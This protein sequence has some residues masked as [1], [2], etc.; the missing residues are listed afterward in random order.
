MCSKSHLGVPLDTLFA[1]YPNSTNMQRARL[2]LRDMMEDKFN[3]LLGQ[4]VPEP[5]AVGQVIAE[6]G[7][8]DE[9]A[10]ALG[11][12]AELGA[13]PNTRAHS[14]FPTL[15]PER[16]RRYAEAV[17]GSALIRAVSTALFVLSPVPLLG[18]IAVF[19]R[20]GADGLPN[21]ALAAGVVTLLVIVTM[22]LL[23]QVRRGA[24]LEEFYDIESGEF[25]RTSRSDAVAHELWD[26]NRA[27]V[28]RARMISVGLWVLSPVPVLLFSLLG[29]DNGSLVL[30]GV[31]LTLCMVAIGL[32][33]AMLTN[34]TEGVA[35]TLLADP[36]I[37]DDD[38]PSNP[39][40]RV[41]TAVYWP[42]VVVIFLAWSFIWDAW[43]ISWLIWP[44][45]GVL[46]GAVW[47]LDGAM[48]SHRERE[49]SRR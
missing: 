39:V 27:G 38:E 28:I 1:P 22:G 23:L 14:T 15:Q 37:D 24:M 40:I 4:G 29:E 6:F 42:L 17:R 2:E 32:V 11:I 30:F 36:E 47:A 3:D 26:D 31:I 45:A 33:I 49:S 48:T 35:E 20:S 13:V 10:P 12:D 8:L 7:S 9:V 46:Y 41:I 18:L 5:E 16:A 34:W 25:T 43:G 44:F 19:D 21:G